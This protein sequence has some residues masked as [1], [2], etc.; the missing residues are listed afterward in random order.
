MFTDSLNDI[1][2][3]SAN[4]SI[5]THTFIL[6]LLKGVFVNDYFQRGFCQRI[7]ESV[8]WFITTLLHLPSLKSFV[9]FF[10]KEIIHSQKSHVI[11]AKRKKTLE[12]PVRTLNQYPLR[13]GVHGMLHF[14]VVF[15]FPRSIKILD[16]RYFFISFPFAKTKKKFFSISFLPLSRT[17]WLLCVAHLCENERHSWITGNNQIIHIRMFSEWLAD[18]LKHQHVIFGHQLFIKLHSLRS[19]LDQTI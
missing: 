8:N 13:L 3:I 4:Y 2:R 18:S 5:S 9:F 6:S 19:R 17:F 12:L 7:Y 10:L 16:I 11:K 14:L 1:E 15:L